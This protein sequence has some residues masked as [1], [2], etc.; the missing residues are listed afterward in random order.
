M[1]KSFES[2]NGK[3][4]TCAIC[5]RVFNMFAKRLYLHNMLKSFESD[6]GKYYTCAHPGI[7]FTLINIL[8]SF[9][10]KF[11]ARRL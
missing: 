7:M 1:F 3:N 8:F 5:S 9:C 4:Y 6:K 11:Q 2:D 10:R